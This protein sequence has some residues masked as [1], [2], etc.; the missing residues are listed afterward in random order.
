MIKYDKVKDL[1]QINAVQVYA[2]IQNFGSAA[3]KLS[4]SYYLLYDPAC[5]TMKRMSS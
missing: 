2:S 4:C 5:E 3:L 1:I